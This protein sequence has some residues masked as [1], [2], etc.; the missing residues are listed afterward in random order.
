MSYFPPSQLASLVSA[1]LQSQLLNNTGST[2]AAL[3]PVSVNSSGTLSLVDVTN[4]NSS[5]DTI[6]IA[7]ASIPNASYG[8]VVNSGKITSVVSLGFNNGNELYIGSNGLLTNIAPTVGS[9]GFVSGDFCIKVG[10]IAQN[11]NNPFDQDLYL[12]IELV[13]QL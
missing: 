7:I 6:G 1:N 12:S 11:Q 10:I 2:I 4:L 3:T 13:V 8:P 5:I 9:N